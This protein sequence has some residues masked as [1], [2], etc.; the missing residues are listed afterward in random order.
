MLVWKVLCRLVRVSRVG[1]VTMMP[2]LLIR[3]SSLP[4]LVSTCCLAAVIEVWS[5]TSIWR[6]EMVPFSE[7]PCVDWTLS[8]AF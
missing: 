7:L 6:S 2:A 8:S 3:T 5:V 1:S 4:K